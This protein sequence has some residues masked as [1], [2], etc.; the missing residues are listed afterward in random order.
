MIKVTIYI[1]HLTNRYMGMDSG[2]PLFHFIMHTSNSVDWI[3]KIV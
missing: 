2:E 3:W 1:V